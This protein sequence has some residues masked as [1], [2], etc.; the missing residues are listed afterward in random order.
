MAP[1]GEWGTITQGVFKYRG[2]TLISRW[3]DIGYVWT[4]SLISVTLPDPIGFGLV[5]TAIVGRIPTSDL[6]Q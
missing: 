5:Q 6:G 2:D 3:L 1:G 4:W